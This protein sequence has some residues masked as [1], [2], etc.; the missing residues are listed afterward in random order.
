MPSSSRLDETGGA[1]L[2][3]REQLNLVETIL[4]EFARPTA[5]MR[6]ITLLRAQHIAVVACLRAVGHILKR[7]DAD[8]PAKAKWLKDRWPQWKAEPIFRDFIELD[9]N[10]LLKEFRGIINLPDTP[11]SSPVVVADPGMPEGVTIL[12][13]F[14]AAQLKSSDGRRAVTLFREAIAFWD[15]RLREFEQAFPALG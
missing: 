3:A 10:R 9:R 8:T 11:V 2:V 5:D 14:D 12:V 7:V 13:D 4:A 15:A 6:A 1:M